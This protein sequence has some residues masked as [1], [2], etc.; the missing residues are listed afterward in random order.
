MVGLFASPLLP[1]QRIL[2]SLMQLLHLCPTPT[3]ILVLTPV[4]YHLITFIL[5]VHCA[6]E[7]MYQEGVNCEYFA[8][9]PHISC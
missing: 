5:S 3:S 2:L 7:V 8:I 4:L 1:P 9:Y 6:S